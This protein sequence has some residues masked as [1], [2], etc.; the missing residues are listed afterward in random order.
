MMTGE[1]IH[2]LNHLISKLNDLDIVII[3]GV[4][5]SLTLFQLHFPPLTSPSQGTND[6]GSRLHP[7]VVLQNIEHL[8]KIV[9]DLSTHQHPV[10]SV[11]VSIPFC[12]WPTV[13][14]TARREINDGIRSYAQRNELKVAFLDA[15]ELLGAEKDRLRE[16]FWGPDRVHL[17]EAGYDQL[18]SALYDVIVA[19]LSNKFKKEK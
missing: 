5:P 4:S 8:H 12:G 6:L 14:D 3:L 10:Y 15:D 9:H 13:N 19:F 18:G 1:M 2:K 7:S 11:A 16:A 17:S